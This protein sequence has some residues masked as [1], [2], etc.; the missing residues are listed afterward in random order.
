[1]FIHIRSISQHFQCC[2][3]SQ[4]CRSCLVYVFHMS[5]NVLC[6]THLKC[7][8]YLSILLLCPWKGSST[9]LELVE[10]CYGKT[11]KLPFPYRPPVFTGKLYFT[12]NKGGSLKL[13]MENGEVSSFW[14]YNFTWQMSGFCSSQSKQGFEWDWTES[15]LSWLNV[16]VFSGKGSTGQSFHW[17]S[18]FHRCERKVWWNIF[19]CISWWNT[20][21][22]YHTESFA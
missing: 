11:Y 13:L 7:S 4:I 21:G 5:S 18:D 3:W 1:M 2:L 10:N 15:T 6:L 22:C 19:H 8:S 9:C 17:Q 20:F 16:F 12:P 14:W